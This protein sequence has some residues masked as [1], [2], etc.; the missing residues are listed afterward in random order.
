MVG[1]FLA[2]LLFLEALSP[3]LTKF[4]VSGSQACLLLALTLCCS[5]HLAIS[6][7]TLSCL[8][9]YCPSA[10]AFGQPVKMWFSVQEAAPHCLQD[11]SSSL[12]QIFRLLGVGNRSA[13]ERRRMLNFPWSVTAPSKT[14]VTPVPG[15]TVSTNPAWLAQS[16][17]PGG[18]PLLPHGLFARQG[19][20][21]LWPQ[22][23]STSFC[24]MAKSAL[25]YHP[26]RSPD[27]SGG[28]LLPSLLA[29][30]SISAAF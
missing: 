30:A 13:T 16:L 10:N 29:G 1:G 17:S 28:I 9:L 23:C 24:F 20:F 25:A 11:G 8:H 27:V 5:T 2:A 6:V 14:A 4:V 15:P 3:S 26:P 22:L 19:L 7:R 12:P 21:W 18:S